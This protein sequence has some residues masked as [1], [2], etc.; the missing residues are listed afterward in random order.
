MIAEL[1][2]LF[3]FLIEYI[4]R[5]YSARN[6]KKYVFSFYVVIAVP[7]GIIVSD[8]GDVFRKTKDDVVSSDK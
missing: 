7:T 1:V 4:L 6:R 3:L 5:I 8:Y 2:I